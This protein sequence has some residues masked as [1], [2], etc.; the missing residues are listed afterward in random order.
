MR[1]DVTQPRLATSEPLEHFFGNLR[2][3]IREFTVLEFSQLAEKF[4]RRLKMMFQN[5]FRPSREPGKGYMAS[6]EDW[7][8]KFGTDTSVGSMEGAVHLQKDGDSVAAQLWSTVSKMIT[9]S[10]DLMRKLLGAVGVPNEEMSPFCRSFTSLED[11]RDE[12][13]RYL[14]RTFKY[15]DVQGASALDNDGNDDDDDDDDDDVSD[16]DESV[17]SM[18]LRVKLFAEAMREKGECD[19]DDVVEVDEV[20]SPTANTVTNSSSVG[21]GGDGNATSKMSDQLMS[22]VRSLM[23]HASSSSDFGESLEHILRSSSC[24]AN[25]EHISGSISS[26]RKVKSLVERWIARPPGGVRK[27]GAELVGEDILIERDVIILANVKLGVGA[28]ASTVQCKFRVLDVLEKYYNK[29]FMSLEP[30]K[31][32]RKETKRYKVEAR[33]LEV[34]AMNEYSDVPLYGSAFKKN[35]IAQNIMDDMI[36]GVVGKLQAVG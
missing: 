14:P 35:D 29:W 5:S 7:V 17:D 33:M 32:F 18:G 36:I 19:D 11:L 23:T 27:D 1:D 30:T 6:F 34:N 4:S 2:Q 24:L 12:Y 8:L 9:F 25:S 16:K 21:D 31:K 20:P 28:A 13:I 22:N 26:S 15:E 3:M 10:S